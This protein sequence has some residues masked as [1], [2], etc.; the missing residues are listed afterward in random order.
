MKRYFAPGCALL[1]YKPELADKVFNF[2]HENLNIYETLLSCCK[3]EPLVEQG[4]EVINICPGCD[5]RYR[6]DY[7]QTSTVSL[8]EIID[9]S[10]VFPFPDYK[11]KIMT[12]NDACPTRDQ[13]RIHKAIRSLLK[14]MNITLV[15][16]AKTGTK[17]V[18][19]GDTFYGEM[20]TEKVNQ[21]MIKRAGEM[22]V[23]DVVVYCVSC[24]K[25]M[26]IGGKKPHYMV[27][28]L[29]GEETIP[30]TIDTDKWHQELDEFIALH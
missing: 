6:N 5:K 11:G 12:S 2:L 16:P 22:P 8:W 10:D 14:K 4:T 23:D 20:P 18:C 19:C 21:Q 24:T 17:G 29:F 28:L 3:H 26:F 25:S 1:I 7:A 27:D 9:N 13:E 15:E 30:K